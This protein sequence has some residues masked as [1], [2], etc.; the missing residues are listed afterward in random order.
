MKL[1]NI[2][3]AVPFGTAFLVKIN[4]HP[5]SGWFFIFGHSPNVTGYAQVRLRI[6]LPATQLLPATHKCVVS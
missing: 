2:L 1:N 5:H 6:G 3:K 4:I